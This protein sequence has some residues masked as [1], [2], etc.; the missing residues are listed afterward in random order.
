MNYHELS[1]TVKCQNR[2]TFQKKQLQIGTTCHR[3]NTGKVYVSSILPPTRTFFNIGQINEVMKELCHKN[4]FVFIDHQN[5]T[6]NDLWVDGIH[7]TNSGKAILARDFAE[8][9]NEFLCQNS[10]FQRSFIR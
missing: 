6:S 10:N 1:E 4:D 5:I 3:Y 7:L 8:K 2:K 9:V